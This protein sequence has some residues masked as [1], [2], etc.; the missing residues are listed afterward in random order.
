VVVAPEKDA[1]EAFTNPATGEWAGWWHDDCVI[2]A[3][4][5][6][7]SVRCKLVLLS[8]DGQHFELFCPQIWLTGGGH[9]YLGAIGREIYENVDPFLLNQ[10]KGLCPTE[11][12]LD[13]PDRFAVCSCK[14]GVTAREVWQLGPER[15][16]PVD[17][18]GREQI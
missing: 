10:Y 12:R 18:P 4:P 5:V 9:T 2:D 11:N 15:W 17:C 3:Q 6:E 1:G 13:E 8:P 7:G 14:F 16:A